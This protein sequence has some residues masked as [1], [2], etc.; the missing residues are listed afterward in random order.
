MDRCRD[1]LRVLAGRAAQKVR[2]EL[3]SP[4]VTVPLKINITELMTDCCWIPELVNIGS[5][6]THSIYWGLRDVTTPARA[7]L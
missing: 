6:V 1:G 3:Q 4:K 5:S 2:L 7:R